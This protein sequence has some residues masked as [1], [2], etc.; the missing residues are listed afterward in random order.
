MKKKIIA[1]ISLFLGLSVLLGVSIK[2]LN[3]RNNTKNNNEDTFIDIK[4]PLDKEETDD[5]IKIEDDK[6]QVKVEEDKSDT[7]N[8]ADKPVNKEESKLEDSENKK[9]ELNGTNKVEENK[10]EETV[11]NETAKEEENKEE[12]NLEPEKTLVGLDTL[13]EDEVTYKY[14]VKITNIKTYKVKTYSDGTVEKNEAA[15]KTS[16]DKSTYS[17]TTN[18]LK[19]EALSLF[20]QNKSTYNEVAN[21][22]NIYR[23][24]LGR[25]N[26]TIDDELSVIATIRAL[27][28]AW[29]G[30]I[31]DISHTRPNGTPWN[32]VL[33]EMNYSMTTAGENIAAGYRTAKSVSEGWRNSQGHYENMIDEKFNKIGI[34]MVELN[35]DKFWVQLFSN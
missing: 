14:G 32:T 20:G 19:S 1:L 33:D 30:D 3:E 4:E 16:Y 22:V 7:Q 34:G 8:E 6:E 27:E 5:I 15:S 28:L 12:E 25:N 24:E 17:A 35:G 31:M 26:L 9:E 11:K 21:Y 29:S 18:E 2:L 10:K 13:E 23:S